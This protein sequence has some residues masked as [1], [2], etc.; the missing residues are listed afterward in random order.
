MDL[1]NN[2]FE[3]VLNYLEL[4]YTEFAH[5]N[6][7]VNFLKLYLTEFLEKQ[8]NLKQEIINLKQ[9]VEELEFLSND[10]E[11]IK[12]DKYT[13]INSYYVRSIIDS[14]KIYNL[15]NS[16]DKLTYMNELKTL[17]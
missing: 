5:K 10:I 16:S 14:K 11:H 3:T 6:I 15:K 2:K 13:D 12:N 9:K 17:H 4:F 8:F 7:Q 1:L